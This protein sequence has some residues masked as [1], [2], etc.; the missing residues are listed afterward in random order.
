[1][2]SVPS[3]MPGPRTHLASATADVDGLSSREAE[4]RRRRGEGNEAV[5]ASSRGYARIVRTNVFN[6][7]NS[8]LFGIGAALLAL[9][10]YGDALI[11]VSI[12][13]LNA[14]ISAV[15]EIRAQRQRDQRR[16]RRR[17]A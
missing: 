3:P 6:I 16:L 1:M 4:A 13:L 7:Y 9:G 5:S 14:V 10:R 17:G 15:Q 2:G 11:S 8:I 12:G